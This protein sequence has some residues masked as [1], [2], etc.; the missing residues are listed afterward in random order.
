MNAC[1]DAGVLRLIYTSSTAVVMKSG[2]D[3]MDLD[4]TTP[5]PTVEEHISHYTAGKMLGEKAVLAA[6]GKLGL[7]T[8]AVRIVGVTG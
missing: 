1:Q 3:S 6:N 4:E 7:Y 8:T 2:E 5:Y